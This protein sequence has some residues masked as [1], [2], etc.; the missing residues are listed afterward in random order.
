MKGGKQMKY[1]VIRGHLL[2][3]FGD[4]A[5]TNLE[6]TAGILVK[7]EWQFFDQEITITIAQ[8]INEESLPTLPEIQVVS[9]ETAQRIINDAQPEY[10]LQDIQALQLD[11][12]LSN[13]SIEKYD[14]NQPLDSQ[15]NLGVLYAAQMAGVVKTPKVILPSRN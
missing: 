9:T 2:D 1:A 8:V 15:H 5:R 12:Q 10:V 14:P 3:I 13:K 11:I 4:A 7:P 6:E